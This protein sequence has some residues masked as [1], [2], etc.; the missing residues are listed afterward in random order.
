MEKAK[1]RISRDTVNSFVNFKNKFLF[2]IGGC[3]VYMQGG[4]EE[5]MTSVE[6]YNLNRDS[7]AE[8]P[9]LNIARDSHTSCILGDRIYTFFGKSTQSH[10]VLS[11]IE[12]LNVDAMEE[13]W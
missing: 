2:V 9:S 10:E 3:T 11:T 8:G 5:S 6:I 7:W 4:Q 12:F 1:P 13:G